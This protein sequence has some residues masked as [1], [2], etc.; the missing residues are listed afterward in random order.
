MAKN[1]PELLPVLV[2]N[3]VTDAVQRVVDL[4]VNKTDLIDMLIGDI[5]TELRAEKKT[6]EAAWRKAEVAYKKRLT[7]MCARHYRALVGQ[8]KRAVGDGDIECQLNRAYHYGRDNRYNDDCAL[9]YDRFDI[10]YSDRNNREIR[11]DISVP[12]P[13]LSD[14]LT[15]ERNAAIVLYKALQEASTKLSDIADK[16]VMVKRQLTRKILESSDEG[17]LVLGQ[18]EGM[19]K[20]MKR[21]IQQGKLTG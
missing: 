15:T 9:N 17:R 2:Q 7:S 20:E 11:I 16:G 19:R 8:V 13:E 1:N 10:D 18:L 12:I 4:R 21:R 3:K 14:A 5:T 6:A